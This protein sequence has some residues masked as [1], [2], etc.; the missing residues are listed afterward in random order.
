[1]SVLRRS[2]GIAFP[3]CLFL[4][5]ATTGVETASIWLAASG[6]RDLLLAWTRRPG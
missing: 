6:A 2:L 5:V 1:M 3:W 4:R